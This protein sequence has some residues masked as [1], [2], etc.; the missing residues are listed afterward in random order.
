MKKVADQQREWVEDTVTTVRRA[1]K[2]QR[3]HRFWFTRD[4]AV[5]MLYEDFKE[6]FNGYRVAIYQG[7]VPN[8]YYQAIATISYKGQR[9]MTLLSGGELREWIAEGGVVHEDDE[10]AKASKMSDM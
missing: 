9:F 6:T 10:T 8:Q 2:L 1:K 3:E 4:L 7:S 5:S